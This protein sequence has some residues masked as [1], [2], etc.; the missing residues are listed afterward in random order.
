MPFFYNTYRTYLKKRFGKPVLKIPINGGFSCPNRDGTK[1]SSG[2]TFCDNSSFSP[3]ALDS[4]SVVSQL[5]TSIQRASSKVELF[6][7]YLQP[8]TNTYGTVEQLKYIY[9]PIIAIPGVIGLAVGTRPDCLSSEV[10]DYLADI[11]KRTYL[12][13]EIGLQS[14]SDETLAYNN[15]GH[16]Y[17]DFVEAVLKLKDRAVESVAHVMVGLPGDTRESMLNTARELAKLPVQGIKIHQL[18]II[19]GTQMEEWYRQGKVIPLTLEEYAL[20]VSDFI[21]LL[22][23][24]QYIHRILA[25]S[26]PEHGLVS[27]LWSAEKMKS[28]ALIKE[29]MDKNGIQQGSRFMNSPDFTF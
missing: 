27:P 17:L 6:I 10:C 24:D 1:S 13:I 26:K 29:Y 22:R 14:A 23:P 2:C 18:M 28:L 8:F 12:S 11:A 4:S 20:L 15:R 16:T 3:A 19:R 7:A 21:S 25:D 5:T 9:E